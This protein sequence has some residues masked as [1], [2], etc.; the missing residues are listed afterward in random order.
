MP[1][2]A[3]GSRGIYVELLQSTL[4][5]LG[6]YF[7]KIDGVFG[8]DT[9]KAVKLFQQNWNLTVDGIVGAN[10]WNALFPYIYGYTN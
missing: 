8:K 9:E 10:T 3:F 4:K 5:K 7:G 1:V 2:L 6:L